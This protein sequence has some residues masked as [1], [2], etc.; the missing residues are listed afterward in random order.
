VVIVVL[1]PVQGSYA[2]IACAPASVSKSQSYRCEIVNKIARREAVSTGEFKSGTSNR[3]K[4]RA[5][6]E[7]HL[8]H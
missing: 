8:V 1:G 2:D 3:S 6:V 4:W 7:G 5:V